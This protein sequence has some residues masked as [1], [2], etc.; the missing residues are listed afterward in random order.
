MNSKFTFLTKN[1]QLIW[2]GQELNPESLMY[3]MIMTYEIKGNI[4]FTYF[5][6]A[7]TKLVEKSD[8]LRSVFELKDG[9]PIQK[10]LEKI[11]FDLEFKDFSAEKKPKEKYIVWQKER[12][13]QQ[14]NLQNCL[15]DAVFI[16]LAD[17][18]FIWYLNQHH[19]ITDGW[20]N[21]IML[22]KM[23]DLYGQIVENSSSEIE[24]L[25]SFQKFVAYEET[26]S[27]SKK[28]I[29]AREHWQQKLEKLPKTPALYHKKKSSLQTA[30][31]R[32]LINLGQERSQKIKELA[33][34]TEIR[35]W[36]L[37]V[38]LHNIFLTTLYAFLYR[39][40][41][42]ESLV[43][44][45]P[46]HNRINKD[47]KNTIG[48]FVEVFP[49]LLKV[50]ETDTLLSLFKKV[51]IESNSFLKNVQ[52]GASSSDL[53]R[54]FNVFYNYINATN[55]NFNGLEVKTSWVHPEHTD[56]RH[57]IRL[58]VHDFDNTGEIK[59]YFDLNTKLF[60][61]EERARI[62][63]HFLAVLD[64]FIENKEQNINNVSIISSQE[65]K[66]IKD[67][68]KTEVEFNQKETLLTKFE[69]Q[70]LKT[71]NNIAL[72]FDDKILTYHEFNEKSNQVARFLLN[73]NIK[74]NDIIV[75]SLERSLEMMIYLYGI[76][77][78][79]AAYLP[80]ETT[81]PS[82]RLSFII[83][84]AESKLL[85]YNHNCISDTILKETKCLDT[86]FLNDKISVLDTSK[87]EVYTKPED[88]AYIIYTSG[89]T[90]KP[91]GVQ[92]H[93]KGICNRINWMNRDYPLTTEDVL[94]Q[95]TPITF[96]VSVWEIFWPLQTGASLVIEKPEGHK[97]P[98]GLINTIIKNRISNIH[99]VPSML[100][101]FTD[102]TSVKECISLK[103]IFSSGEA[104]SASLVKK[105][106]VKLQADIYNLYG[107]TEASIDVTSWK[108]E[109]NSDT[110]T[111]PIGYPT[112]NTKLYIVDERMNLSPIGIPGELYIAGTQVA[113]GYL[114]REK[115]TNE[116]FLDDIFS[117]ALHGKMYKTGDL[118][119]Y[120]ADGAIEYLGRIDYQVKLRGQRIELGE[121]ERTLEKHKYISK[122]VVLVDD[123]QN[124]I[125]HYLG[126]FTNASEIKAYLESK[127]PKHMIPSFFVHQEKLELLPSGKI[128]RKKLL[129]KDSDSNLKIEKTRIAP[130]TEIEEL[131]CNIWKEVL[132]INEIG[133]YENFINIGGNSL[134]AISITS[135]VKETLELDL[136]SINDVFNY[137]TIA[138]YAKN[139]EEIITQLLEE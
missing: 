72:K 34:T 17:N 114:N 78:V 84:D 64:A 74:Q 124:L 85:F 91:K 138:S 42:Q 60:N 33:T 86:R 93:H 122:A 96:D 22:S 7:F 132:H 55:S 10:Y 81:I 15:F 87:N 14:F 31:K 28:G 3:N 102:L 76:L 52:V 82:E 35:G 137:P 101:I 11:D 119:K 27:N 70:V 49:L 18:H 41:G 88:L 48:F 30:S 29:S 117:D 129:I 13:K 9:K 67:W 83:K 53:N 107:P 58:H 39:V 108:C 98:E 40:T 25:P 109:R 77:K 20:S 110:E 80:V 116:R 21:T 1:Q 115:L 136:I 126:E 104:L 71:P 139:I 61:S 26:I 95:K 75:V 127:L 23:S 73:N 118:V 106:H 92:C 24:D 113:Q 125:A 99:F 6:Q 79:G 38:T 97:N 131:I 103:R 44:G 135:R 2:L 133:I 36:F 8:V 59:L 68:N 5:K 62:P 69:N 45:A 94:L 19:L 100:E 112:A 90:G 50:E 134:I 57:K 47:F 37:D 120:R 121:I 54:N 32:Y 105:T 89:S 56:P 51:Q 4:I 65:V 43:I 128:D 46:T 16:K 123:Q 12:V 130:Q 66:T 111:I 63:Q